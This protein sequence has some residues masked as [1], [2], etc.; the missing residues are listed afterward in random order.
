MGLITDDFVEGIEVGGAGGNTTKDR[1]L[2][3]CLNM[4]GNNL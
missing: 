2:R 4:K 1:P 3:L